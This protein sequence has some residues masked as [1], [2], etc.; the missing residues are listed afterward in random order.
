MFA[1]RD[2]ME[3]LKNINYKS[4]IFIE[5]ILTV[6]KSYRFKVMPLYYLNFK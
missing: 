1:F 4:N 6:V 5:F 2:I 3:D